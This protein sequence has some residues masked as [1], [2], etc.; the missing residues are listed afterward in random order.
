MKTLL[1][2]TFAL[3]I[4][5]FAVNAQDNAAI[6]KEAKMKT[7]K[8]VKALEL[9]DDQQV[10]VHRQNYELAMN[11][12]RLKKMDV[13][14]EEKEEM[15]KAYTKRMNESMKGILTVDQFTKYRSIQDKSEADARERMKK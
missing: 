2:L 13:S 1:T 8:L 11:A 5:V 9:T 15:S 3:L 6:E 10:L 14:D 12:A 7:E 4:S